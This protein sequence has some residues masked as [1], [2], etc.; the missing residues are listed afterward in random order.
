MAACTSPTPENARP[1]LSGNTR[2]GRT[3]CCMHT[4]NRR[5]WPS[6]MTVTFRPAPLPGPSYQSTNIVLSYARVNPVIYLSMT[7]II[8]FPNNFHWNRNSYKDAR[9]QRTPPPTQT[10]FQPRDACSCQHCN[11]PDG[12]APVHGM[13]PITEAAGGP[14]EWHADR[15]CYS[16]W[17]RPNR[18][19]RANNKLEYSPQRC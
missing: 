16:N 2:L 8:K 17:S 15:C 18:V 1:D 19:W 3:S 4:P 9:P 14:R 13:L 7:T 5:R 6:S 10:A 12:L 11:D